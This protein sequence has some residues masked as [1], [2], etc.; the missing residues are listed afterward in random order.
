VSRQ[1]GFCG[2]VVPTRE[3]DERLGGVDAVLEV[4]RSAFADADPLVARVREC[5]PEPR[6]ILRGGSLVNDSDSRCNRKIYTVVNGTGVTPG[7]L[8]PGGVRRRRRFR[9]HPRQRIRWV[10]PLH[11]HHRQSPRAYPTVQPAK[12]VRTRILHR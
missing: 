8:V 4:H 6:R 12:P 2:V 7:P 5:R 1:Q 9:F 3:K 11:R 10:W